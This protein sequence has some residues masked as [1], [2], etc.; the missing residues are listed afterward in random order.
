MISRWCQVLSLGVSACAT[1][2]TAPATQASPALFDAAQADP[3]AVA[4]ADQVMAA[5]GGDL[6]WARAKEIIWNQE[7]RQGESTVR[8]RHAWDRWNG[9]HQATL[10]QA[11]GSPAV[12]VMY[13]LYSDVGTATVRGRP[14]S[15]SD[16][17]RAIAAARERWAEDTY[18][19]FMPMKLK[20][21]GVHLAWVEERSDAGSTEAK[22]D[23]L[24]V[25][26]AA[27]VGPR[28]GDVYYVVVDRQTHLPHIV[29]WVRTGQNDDHRVGYRWEKWVEAGGLKFSTHRQNLGFA[30]ESITF[31]DIQVNTEPDDS[32]YVPLVRE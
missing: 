14:V 7:L 1:A 11:D 29:E 31:S 13:E 24:K 2:R 16:A 28:P 5:V 8:G 10:L 21:P 30:S 18:M 4:I 25:T 15:S 20:D 22:Y 19:L 23:V 17:R 32:L 6:A 12:R 9:R 26:F 3:K 27:G